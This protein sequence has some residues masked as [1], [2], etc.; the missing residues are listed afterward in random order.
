M[1]WAASVALPERRWL[2]VPQEYRNLRVCVTRAFFERRPYSAEDLLDQDKFRHLVFAWSVIQTVQEETAHMERMRRT[3]PMLENELA[4]PL[5]VLPLFR[6]ERLVHRWAQDYPDIREREEEDNPPENIVPRMWRLINNLDFYRAYVAYPS[7]DETDFRW[8]RDVEWEYPNNVMGDTV[9]KITHPVTRQTI[10]RSFPHPGPD[11]ESIV[12][13]RW[14]QLMWNSDARYQW[15]MLEESEY[16][17][18][19]T[20]NFYD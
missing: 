6:F 2:T 9:L 7:C 16:E 15:N 17:S 11:M 1:D 3:Q 13:L 18:D 12:R 19:A 8:M 4:R 20:D 5:S 10:V 14:V